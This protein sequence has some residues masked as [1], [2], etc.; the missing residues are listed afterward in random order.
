MLTQDP[1]V[2]KAVAKLMALSEDGEAR[3]IAES[4]EK[5]RRDIAA[6]ERAAREEG[7]E[8]GREE[9]QLAMARKALEKGLPLETVMAITGLS[10]SAFS[11]CNPKGKTG[12][13]ISLSHKSPL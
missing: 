8:K 13:D 4:R 10:Q 7:L 2:G 5:L 9:A 12:I 1:Q 6:A 11:C 3:M